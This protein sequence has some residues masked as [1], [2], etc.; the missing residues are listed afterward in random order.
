M[1]R[2]DP[3][4]YRLRTKHFINII[5]VRLEF[6]FPYQYLRIQRN[7]AHVRLMSSMRYA[8]RAL[9]VASVVGTSIG[10]I[11]MCVSIWNSQLTWPV[12]HFTSIL[13]PTVVLVLAFL[14]KQHVESLVHYQRIREV[15]FIPEMAYFAKKVYPEFE[16][17]EACAANE[18]IKGHMA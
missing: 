10:L 11:C 8:S 5:K 3:D 9:I 6:L 4:S 2:A 1:V 13:L 14:L 18:S 15:V 12:A 17:T 7:E 16:F